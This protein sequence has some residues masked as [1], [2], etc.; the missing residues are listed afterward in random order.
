MQVWLSQTSVNLEPVA[1]L[2]T[3]QHLVHGPPFLLTVTVLPKSSHLKA[4]PPT[5]TVPMLLPVLARPG[6]QQ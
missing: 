1:L 4:P 3:Q 2:Q 5:P 6:Q